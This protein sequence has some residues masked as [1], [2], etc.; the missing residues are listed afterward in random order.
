MKV[1]KYRDFS[2]PSGEDF[3]RLATILHRGAL[4]CARPDTLNDPE[5]FGWRCDY[6]PTGD[7]IELIARLLVACRSRSL[8][9]ARETS[10][11]AVNTNRLRLLAEPVMED[12]I[13]KSRNEVGLLCLGMS[14]DNDTL[15]QRYGGHGAGVAVELDVPDHLKG[16]ALFDVQYLADKRI[17]IDQ[18]VAA[19][20][21]RSRASEVYSLALLSKPKF[22]HDEEEIR[23]VS[24]RQN[25]A[26]VIEGSRVTRLFTG[27]SLSPA[28]RDRIS[29]LA[30][31]I[32]V[33]PRRRR[34]AYR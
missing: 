19:F 8:R 33:L 16:Q 22:W 6:D 15:W 12:L 10:A 28:V 18:L 24:N 21:E 3:Q 29:S 1:Y 30:R 13:R 27:D 4:W 7:T 11:A 14:A 26:V 34:G 5:E 31:A 20:L 23:F 2:S 17:H 32:E 25:V 9:E